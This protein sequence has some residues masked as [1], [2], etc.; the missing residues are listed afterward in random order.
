MTEESTSLDCAGDREY[1]RV[2]TRLK[3][4][5]QPLDA[6]ERRSRATEILANVEPTPP[7]VDSDLAIWLERI[8][9]KLDRAL[10]QL[11]LG[12]DHHLEEADLRDIELSGSGL[13]F[14]GSSELRDGDFLLLEME[15][16]SHPPRML[17]CTGRVVHAAAGPDGRGA[18]IG[19]AFET[20]REGDREAIIQYTVAV[21]REQLRVE[22]SS[23]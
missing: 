18:R 10:A 14:D 12:A 6:E 8:E 1:F 11:G 2:R 5:V 20:I 23:G 19:I 4:R 22:A 9:R 3:L 13:S 17:R 15:L 16:P 7:Q 21:Q